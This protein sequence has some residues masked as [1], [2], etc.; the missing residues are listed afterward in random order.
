MCTTNNAT[1]T[2]EEQVVAD[3]EVDDTASELGGSIASSSTSLSESIYHYRLENGRTYHRYKEG[4]YQF[5]NDERELE[6][7]DLQHHMF[8]LCLD[9][10]LGVAPP[11]DEGS[12]VR[13]VL[14]VGTGTGLWAIEFGEAHPESEVLGVDLSPPLAEVP[15]NVTFEVDDIEEPWLYSRPFDYIHSRVMNSSIRD[16]KQFIQNCYDHLT[17]GGY[18]ELKEV[19]LMPESDDG[20]LQP[21]S[22]LVKTYT[23]LGEALRIFGCAFQDVPAMV[24]M[25]KAVGFVDLYVKKFKWPTNTW[26]RDSHYKEIGEWANVNYLTGIEA[27][28]M[29]PFTRALG[30]KKEEVQILLIDVRK[31]F[32][33]RSIHAY[34][35]W[36]AIYGRKPQEEKE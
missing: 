18:L 27:W 10:K 32:N 8:D 3:A 31:E 5:P 17:P 4:K 19:E 30:W 34:C 2:E 1:T 25:M 7:L 9:G 23:L 28:T 12:G 36:Y 24:D 15:P 26:P 11:N 29:A 21:D 35:S 20:T 22:A 13:R 33:D 6:R 14:D 16:W